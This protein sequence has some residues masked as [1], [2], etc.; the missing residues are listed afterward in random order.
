MGEMEGGGGRMCWL[1]AL[2]KKR[3]DK[4]VEDEADA[5]ILKENCSQHARWCC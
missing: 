2:H 4:A 5:R 3:E 1:Q